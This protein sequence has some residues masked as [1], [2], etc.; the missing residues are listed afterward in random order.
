MDNSNNNIINRKIDILLI[1]FP[2]IFPLIYF[3]I[4][5][6]L[7]NLEY[8]LIFFTLLLLAEPHFGAT[9]PFFLSKMNKSII[10]KDK[11][12]YILVPF[13]I[14]LSSIYLF[15]FYDT[16]F[17]LLFFIFNIFHVTRQ[18][19]G[20]SKLYEKIKNKNIFINNSIYFF[21]IYFFLIGIIRFYF[22]NFNLN[23]ENKLILLSSGLLILNFVLFIYFFRD[24]KN[25]VILITGTIMFFPISFVEA[26]IHG[27]IMGV[28]MHYTQYLA[29]TYKVVSNRKGLN[30]FGKVIN[31]E[32]LII[33]LTYGLVMS[34]MSFTNKIDHNF[35]KYLII[36]PILGQMLHF[37]LDGLLWRFSKSHNREVTLK[38]LT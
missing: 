1:K 27:I 7:P 18:S 22:N 3:V 20:I 32:Y 29:L 15:I 16:L 23:I 30:I 9:W 10:L 12:I 6:S 4:L 14:I 35:I 11:L 21:A 17:Y 28:T 13:L 37:Y 34:L 19:V 36:V 2:I 25:F 24:L 26:P 5:Y 8:Y 33:I 31:Y 38:Y